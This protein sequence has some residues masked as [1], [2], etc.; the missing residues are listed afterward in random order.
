[1]SILPG[2]I[3]TALRTHLEFCFTDK[4]CSETLGRQH[5]LGNLLLLSAIRQTLTTE[6]IVD[7]TLVMDESSAE[8]L[9][10]A[11]SNLGQLFGTDFDAVLPELEDVY[12]AAIKHGRGQTADEDSS[13]EPSTGD[14]DSKECSSVNSS[15][16]DRDSDDDGPDTA[17]AQ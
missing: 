10:S 4:G 11:V 13:A 15:S 17:G 1:M 12:F 7:E 16:E 3:E 2:E 8:A 14:S 5:C 9:H 6:T